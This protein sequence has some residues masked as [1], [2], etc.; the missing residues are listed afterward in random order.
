MKNLL[1]SQQIPTINDMS[2][3]I[4]NPLFE[5]FIKYMKDEYQIKLSFEFSRCS[6]RPGWNIKMKRS[7]KNYCL[8]SGRFF[9]CSDCDWKER[10]RKI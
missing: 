4:H 1:E 9:C 7:G 6:W 8:S 5:I 10:K 3:Y 2:K